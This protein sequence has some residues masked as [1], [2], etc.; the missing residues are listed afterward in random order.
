MAS[1]ITRAWWPIALR[2][3]LVVT[4]RPA[5]W[6]RWQCWCRRHST[7]APSDPH[8]TR[9]SYVALRVLDDAAY[10]AGVWQGRH[11]API[12]GGTAPVVRA[13]AAARTPRLDPADSGFNRRLD[14]TGGD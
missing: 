8:S 7:G 3:A 14:A 9:C 13:V 5:V 6:W 4:T 11:R 2:L 10:G 12:A 1:A